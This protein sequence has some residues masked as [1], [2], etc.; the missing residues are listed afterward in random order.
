MLA[1]QSGFSYL[2]TV[3]LVHGVAKVSLLVPRDGHSHVVFGDGLG[4]LGCVETGLNES[5]A[6][7]RGYHWLQ[8][9]SSK[10][11]HMPSLGSY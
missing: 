4:V 9:G 5:L 7:L 2:E 3:V 6:S 8:F 10:G 1:A 11:V